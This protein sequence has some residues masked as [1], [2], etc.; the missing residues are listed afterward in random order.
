MPTHPMSETLTIKETT[1]AATESVGAEL[2]AIQAESI[3]WIPLDGAYLHVGDAE[4]QVIDVVGV[5][6]ASMAG[7]N[8][9]WLA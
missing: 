5:A 1:H 8:L 2:R 9:L 4:S 7:A 6:L 3:G